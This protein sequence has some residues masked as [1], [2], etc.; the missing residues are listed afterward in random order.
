M[1]KNEA[2]SNRRVE[3]VLRSRKVLVRVHEYSFTDLTAP[4][5]PMRQKRRAFVYDYVFDDDQRRMVNDARAKADGL[6][7]D[8]K[9][10]DLSKENVVARMFRRMSELSGGPRSGLAGPKVE[11]IID[12][13]VISLSL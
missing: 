9:V 2:R 4:T 13:G 10:T 6:G 5:M 12:S 8:L 3:I 11:P 1:V 7:L